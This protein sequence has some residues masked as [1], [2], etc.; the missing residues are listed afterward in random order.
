MTEPKTG[1]EVGVWFDTDETKD[2]VRT[3]KG[4]L[5]V[6]IQF[7]KTT[8]EHM[9]EPMVI[10]RCPPCEWAAVLTRA[11]GNRTVKRWM[12]LPP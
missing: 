2:R 7:N 10:S 8:P 3:Y 6:V 4:T 9:T 12:I 11:G 1:L 5:P